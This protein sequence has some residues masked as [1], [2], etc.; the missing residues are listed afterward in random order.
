MLKRWMVVAA[1]GFAAFRGLTEYST[2]AARGERPPV[3][4]PAAPTIEID[5]YNSGY[6]IERSECLTIWLGPSAA[7]ECGNLRVVH[8][9]PS[10]RVF[11]KARTPTL[12]Y[13][14]EFA[15]P[16][17]VIPVF[18]KIASTTTQPDTVRVILKVSKDTV[19]ANY[20]PKDTATWLG[21][22]WPSGQTTTRRISMTYDGA[23][24]TTGYYFYQVD[25]SNIYNSPSAT[26]TSTTWPGKMFHI[27][28]G[29]SPFGAGWWLAGV[30]RLMNLGTNEV[31]WIGG[32]GS[33]RF[34][35]RFN[36]SDTTWY[37]PWYDRQYHR[38]WWHAS[39]STYT[40]EEVEG[41]V[42][43]YDQT[44]KHTKTTD[45]FGQVTTFS[46]SSGN[47]S[48]ISLPSPTNLLY[49][50]GYNS[51]YL[52]SVTA[53]PIGGT[54]RVTVLW[55]T[56]GKVDSIQN[57][58]DSAVRFKYYTN[59]GSERLMSVRTN[60]RLVP[61]TFTYDEAR[62]VASSRLGM[63]SGNAS[64]VWTIR[65]GESRGLPNSGSP[66]SVD[67]S[68][69]YTL[70]DGPRSVADTIM[71]FQER[72]GA[73]RRI[74]DALGNTTHIR[75][76]LCNP[77]DE[78]TCAWPI[79][80]L[81]RPGGQIVLINRDNRGNPT[82]VID[83]TGTTASVRDTTKYAWDGKFDQ[84]TMIVPPEKDTIWF[85]IN[86][87]NG[88]REYQEDRRKDTSRV[89]F[90]YD[91]TYP[92]LVT[93][94][95]LPAVG[96]ATAVYKYGY[97]STLRNLAADTTPK[98]FFTTYTMDAI[99]RVTTIDS[100]IDSTVASSRRVQQLR[101]HD[102]VDRVW[103]ETQQTVSVS[104]SQTFTV[105]TFFNP[106]DQPDSVEREMNPDPK[107]IGTSTTRWRYDAAGRAIAVVAT[108][109]RVDSTVFDEAGN[110]VTVVSRRNVAGQG[111]SVQPV[112]MEYDVLDRLTK[113]IIPA[114]T[115]TTRDEGIPHAF[116]TN[117]PYAAYAIP[118]DTLRYTYTVDGQIDS[119]NNQWA[120]I[121]RRYSV[122]GWMVAETLQVANVAGTSFSQ[123]TYGSQFRYDRNGRRIVT[124]VPSQ[125][126]G[127]GQDSIRFTYVRWGAL[128]SVFDV[129]GNWLAHR[130]NARSELSQ[131]DR[132]S[133]SVVQQSAYD[134]DGR[135]IADSIANNGGTS[136][137]RWQFSAL[138]AAKL[139]YDGRDR[140]LRR[141][142]PVTSSDTLL[143]TYSGLG[144][145]VRTRYV[146]KGT[147]SGLGSSVTYAQVESLTVDPLGNITGGEYRDT[148]KV[149]SNTQLASL[150][151]RNVN[152]KP[153]VGR[154][155]LDV[156]GSMTR[157]IKYDSAG[158]VVFTSRAGNS[159]DPLEDRASFYDATNQLVAAEWR[160][161]QDPND[162][163]PKR[164]VVEEYRYDALGR[165]VWTRS[166]RGCTD[167]S[168]NTFPLNQYYQNGLSIECKMSFVRRT[169][170]DGEQELAE[171]NAPGA[172]ADS[173]LWERDTGYVNLGRID[174]KD[175]NP[176]YGRVV[177][178]Y[179]LDVDQPISVARFGYAD[180]PHQGSFTSWDAFA[181][182]P[183][184]DQ[185]GRAVTGV[186]GNG[187]A[188][189][190]YTSGGSACA[191]D[192][193]VQRCV[194]LYWPYSW[195]AYD[196]R[197]GIK[198]PSWHGSL[199]ENKRDHAGVEYRRNRFYDPQSGRFTQEDPI[200]LDGGLNLYGFA[201]GDPVNFS[202]PFG[203]CPLPGWQGK[204]VC[205]AATAA[206]QIPAVQRALNSP[207]VQRGL[208]RARQLGAEG[209]RR[210]GEALGL[211]KNTT[212]QVAGRI[213]DFIDDVSSTLVEVK[214]VSRQA[215]TQ[216]LRDM[217]GA[218]EE[219]GQRFILYTR[220]GTRLSRPLEQAIEQ[221]RIER[222]IIP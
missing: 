114:F 80:R 29:S 110:A 42:V 120:R 125:L 1:G 111:G 182:L 112:T 40:R 123:H 95:T 2:L 88:R 68:K 210:V 69:V 65:A 155:T 113:R 188:V 25:V 70:I 199:L 92:G 136:F 97:H 186:F 126:V 168:D 218:A 82:H 124:K 9:L 46:Y 47:L 19:T 36:P 153:A 171:I 94:M 91:A 103:F 77:P 184:W 16:W 122:Q 138:R 48:Q 10:T 149:G 130:Y 118:A 56:S 35:L 134:A 205:L 121:K 58:G 140:V 84:L 75:R 194:L 100:P 146:Q 191:T 90:A 157:V 32:D 178:A 21:S 154:D 89:T 177:Y 127:A 204:A 169:V 144:S 150:Y 187:W 106:E 45:R 76:F 176:F 96:G 102:L 201:N 173:T 206:V 129:F 72:Y 167:V 132:I 117:D 30:E 135:A 37:A 142:D 175:P 15:H 17:P 64:I 200:G 61:D 6:P 86:S 219:A 66:S 59:G 24:D 161:A 71:M 180:Y 211:V 57:P 43:E 160:W 85:S 49:S 33:A 87:S 12:I 131:L 165:R 11:N 20:Q 162:Q 119:A 14:S 44:G 99:G 105:Q 214:N 5:G 213:P 107:S 74:V 172:D 63:G 116:G 3:F 23:N 53:P 104:P 139:N 51:G 98:G 198:L 101:T 79:Y 163:T 55:N 159:S 151:T 185:Q 50:F 220:E 34:F 193:S 38:I 83:S 67:T 196:Q 8:Q 158:N 141:A 179:G 4:A 41:T 18:V 81:K 192:N 183:L 207:G 216:Q 128:E 221:G 60:R 62:R 190:Q 137:P 222:R 78:Y 217:L 181:I 164:T 115:Y 208:Q 197:K 22:E 93:S 203:L 39:N 108:D 215:F 28:R 202:D 189:R 156:T 143:A 152:Y 54:S 170:W 166:R 212:R 52:S 13:N 147:L 133:A 26:H 209:E 148:V 195:A 27:N 31:V 109:G 145:L 174:A 73:S 7:A